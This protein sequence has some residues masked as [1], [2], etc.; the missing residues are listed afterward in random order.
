MEELAKIIMNYGT[1]TIIIALFIWIYFDDRKNY[2]EEK[3]NNV[4]VLGQLAN[5]N[6]NIA[7]SL[8]LLKT[9]L[10]NQNNKFQMHDEREI[11]NTTEIK[12]TLCRIES[13]VKNK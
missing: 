5:S 10:D 8:N 12:E 3:K 13:G 7:E 2:K 4:E 6:N 9:S 1:S 11:K